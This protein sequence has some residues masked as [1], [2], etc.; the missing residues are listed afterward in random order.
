MT[1]EEQLMAYEP[2]NEQE[3]RDRALML[4]FLREGET[5]FSRGNETAHFTASAWVTNAARDKV[6]LIWHNIYRSWAWTGG[7]ADGERDLLAVA[8]REAEEET[9]VGG[10]APVT[11]TPVSLEILTVDG[12]EKRGRYVPS[13]LHCNVTYLFEA[14]DA[15]PLRA[16]PDENSGARWFPLEE[17]LAASA[18]PWMVERVY[19]KLL[20]KMKK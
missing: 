4:R 1:L 17:A 18:E 14:D 8:R 6:L 13:H 9:G 10:L 12:H 7:H 16:K 15:A 5:P 20:L 19:K 11:D 3:A 2:A